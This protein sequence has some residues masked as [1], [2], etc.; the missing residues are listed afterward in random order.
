MAIWFKKLGNK[1]L[2]KLFAPQVHL[3][4]IRNLFKDKSLEG[5]MKELGETARIY[6]GE[7]DL[8][9]EGY[10][11]TEDDRLDNA[12]DNNVVEE[13][14]EYFNNNFSNPNLLINSYFKNPVN[15]RKKS[16]YTEGDIYTIDRWKFHDEES[17]KQQKLEM[18]NNG[19]KLTALADNKNFGYVQIV[20]GSRIE[21]DT[22]Y[23]ISAKVTESK[24]DIFSFYIAQ[25]GNPSF[26]WGVENGDNGVKYFTFK[27][28][29]NFNGDLYI[30]FGG[31]SENISK[32]NSG[33]YLA[34]KW[35]K[36]EK[37]DKATPFVP[38]S[39]GEE[40]ALCQ[41]YYEQVYLVGK[42]IS[43]DG[44]ALLSTPYKVDKRIAP[45]KKLRI[46]ETE[47][48]LVWY[49]NDWQNVNDKLMLGDWVNPYC[50]Q[51]GI[52]NLGVTQPFFDYQIRVDADAEIY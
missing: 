48:S 29:S 50:C 41:R 45:T 23:T 9:K 42:Y 40:L 43:S 11:I 4:D 35:A 12:E 51:V 22:L 32:I 1:K 10:Y 21:P 38:R 52:P 30:S 49:N 13:L 17:A 34:I 44:S 39:Y 46:S 25:Y 27:T 28:P 20:E 33:D 14:K 19:I 3:I 7:P 26:A 37:G 47:N 31:T 24:E 36:L 18:S 15:Q 6:E 16:V 2:Y 5:A 8:E